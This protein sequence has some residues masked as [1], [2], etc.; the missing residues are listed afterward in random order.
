MSN[1]AIVPKENAN[2][3]V[4]IFY[5]FMAGEEGFALVYIF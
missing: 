3:K 2:N 5:N 4:G 1:Y